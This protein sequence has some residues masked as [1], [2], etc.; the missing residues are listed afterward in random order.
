MK[1][2]T[3]ILWMIPLLL[4]WGCRPAGE[5]PAVPAE[6]D[7]QLKEAATRAVAAE[8]RA[9]TGAPVGENAAPLSTHASAAAIL[10][11]LGEAP[12]LTNEIWIN[13]EPLTL[14]GLRGKVVLIEFWTFG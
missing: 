6:P 2:R 8:T 13:S 9:P 10:P 4:L 1:P 7:E 5:D 12:E 3:L 11:D 14:A